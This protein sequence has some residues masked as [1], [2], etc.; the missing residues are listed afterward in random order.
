MHRGTLM[1]ILASAD[2][3][4]PVSVNSVLF[5]CVSFCNCNRETFSFQEK[6]IFSSFL[7]W[8]HQTLDARSGVLDCSPHKCHP[9][10]LRV[11]KRRVATIIYFFY[12]L[13]LFLSVLSCSGFCAFS[14][15]F[16]LC[17]G[18][19]LECWW[20]KLGPSPRTYLGVIN[21]WHPSSASQLWLS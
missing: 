14:S 4:A 19:C 17:G 13:P 2:A 10:A 8:K 20:G 12:S 7:V 9:A 5:L 6:K 16:P 18:I 15:S 1:F 3:F 21:S 11:E